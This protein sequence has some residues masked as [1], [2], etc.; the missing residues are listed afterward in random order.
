MMRACVRACVRC[1]RA[2]RAQEYLQA[3]RNE[4]QLREWMQQVR[5]SS[6]RVPLSA[7]QQLR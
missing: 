3:K 2:L 5:L 6:P 7:L 1:V 4:K